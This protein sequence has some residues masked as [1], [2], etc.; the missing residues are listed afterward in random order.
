MSVTNC[1]DILVNGSLIQSGYCAYENAFS[2]FG[3]A[4]YTLGFIFIVFM[5]LMYIQNRN[6]A[7][8]LIVTLIGF[9]IFFTMIPVIIKGFIV[10]VML[11]ELFASVYE[12]VIVQQ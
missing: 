3:V 2:F 6:M 4:N 1:F 11:F 10:A 12:W 7:F 9:S 5:V 8:N